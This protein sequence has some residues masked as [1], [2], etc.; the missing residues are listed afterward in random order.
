[1]VVP[2]AWLVH[3]SPP[4]VVR[5]IAP[6][7]PTTVPVF[8]LT[9]DRPLRPTLVPLAWT[10]QVAPPSLLRTIVPCSP[11]ATMVLKSGLATALSHSLVGHGGCT[12]QPDW[13]TA[14]PICRNAM[15]ATQKFTPFAKTF[16][17]PAPKL[18]NVGDPSRAE[19]EKQCCSRWSSLCCGDSLCRCR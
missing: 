3:V 19:A 14:G 13:A 18:E 16:I 9:K 6:E 2:L 12:Y 5:K 4:S 1:M 8:A 7:Y 17:V 15:M 11:T 10:V